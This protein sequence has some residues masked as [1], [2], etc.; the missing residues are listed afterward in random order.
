MSNLSFKVAMGGGLKASFIIAS[1]G[2]ETGTW[3]IRI[4]VATPYSGVTWSTVAG[5]NDPEIWL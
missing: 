2:V 3:D 4:C 5:V 1:T